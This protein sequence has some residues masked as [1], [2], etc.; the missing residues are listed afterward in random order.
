MGQFGVSL[1]RRI[2]KAGYTTKYKCNTFYDL[3][4]QK[5]A[6]VPRQYIVDFS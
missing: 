4:Q 1:G 3:S 2:N 6:Q 5:C